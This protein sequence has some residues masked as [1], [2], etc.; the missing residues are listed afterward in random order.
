MSERDEMI[1]AI[2]LD[3]A[4]LE[5]LHVGWRLGQADD[6]T[7]YD[8]IVDKRLYEIAGAVKSLSTQQEQ[9]K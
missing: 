6:A 8:R 1:E 3:R 2:A 7:K 9:P 4:Y 5:G